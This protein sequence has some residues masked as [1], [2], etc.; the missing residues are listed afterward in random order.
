MNRPKTIGGCPTYD[1]VLRNSSGGELDR[2]SGDDLSQIMADYA[3]EG[4]LSGGD[5]LTII[6]Y[7]EDDE[8]ERC[9]GTG[10]EPCGISFD[11]G[12]GEGE[13]RPCSACSGG[14]A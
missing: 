12:D 10:I 6:D 7:T 13:D 5:T 8:C 2:K 14:A 1:V 11:A 9:G 4:C 3:R